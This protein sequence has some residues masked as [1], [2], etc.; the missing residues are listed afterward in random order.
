MVGAR[1]VEPRVEHA[2]DADC[3]E[4]VLGS[5]H[6][7]ALRVR[8]DEQREPADPEGAQLPSRLALRRPLV[9][10][11]GALGHLHEHGAAAATSSR[12][13]LP[14]SRRSPSGTSSVA[15]SATR[16]TPELV[17]AKGSPPTRRAHA[18]R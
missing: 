2:V 18:A 6:V 10:E 7:V 9:D 4:D 15:V 17:C 14:R 3:F 1:R 8:E 12:G 13:T 11:H 16:S 5:S